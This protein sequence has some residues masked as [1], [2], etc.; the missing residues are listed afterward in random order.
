M[1]EAA[2]ET[3]ELVKVEVLN[4]VQV[5]TGGGMNAILDQIESK[6]RAIPLDPSTASGRDQIRSVAY[7]VVRTKTA[8]DAEGKKLT[9]EWRKNTAKVNEE[10]KKSAERLEALAEEVRKPLTDFENKEKIRVEAHEQALSEMSGMLVMLQANPDMTVELLE[11]HL[12]DFSVLHG[13]RDW[14]EFADRASRLRREV[15]VALI[16]RIEARKKFDADQAELL[17]LR[18]E[19]AD[20]KQRERDEQ[21]KAAAAEAARVEAERK[22]QEAAEGERRRVEA[23]AKAER[24]RVAA[25]ADR[26]RREHEEA[27]QAAARAQREAEEAAEQKRLEEERQRRA[28]EKRATDAEEARIAS[29]KRAD[30]ERIEAQRK[31]VA[32]KAKAAAD[33]KAAQEKAQRDEEAAVE[34]ERE[35]VLGER[36]AAETERLRREADEANQARIRGEIIEDLCAC[37]GRDEDL[38][39]IAD[40]ILAGQIRNVR[41]VY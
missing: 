18:Q 4:A 26:V 27:L 22:A 32:A 17:R 19:E 34:R 30:A 6:V 1:A 7:R 36:Q 39:D 38:S 10:R 31:A 3:Q 24:D 8:L 13:G 16:G 41:V 35:R 14:E 29:E 2:E 15:S 40:A 28:A 33:L 25:E 37:R 21:L 9:E 23:E 11:E 20:R 5:F 12:L